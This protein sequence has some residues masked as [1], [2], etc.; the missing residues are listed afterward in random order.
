MRSQRGLAAV[1]ALLIVAVA[2]STAALMLSQQSAMLDQTSMVVAR[3][4]ADLYAQAGIDWAR[5]ILLE[6]SR[7]GQLDTLDEPWAQPIAALP[8][9]RAVVSGRIEDEQGKFNLNNLARVQG[10][11]DDQW[12]LFNNILQRAGLSLDL[13]DAVKDWVD[14]D[15]DLSALDGNGGA[16]DAYYLALARPYRTANAPMTQVDELYRVR[17]FD[18]DKVAKLRPYVTALPP[19]PAAPTPIN[20][21]TASDLVLAAITGATDATRIAALV[22]RRAKKPF[23]SPDDF[24]SAVATTVGGGA[25]NV[26]DVSSTYFAVRVQV[27]QDD[28]QLASDALL[29]RQ[30]GKSPVIIWRRPRY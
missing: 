24:R 16:E 29:Q 13:A 28:V 11:S 10:K 18:P 4:Q 17:G 19:D 14:S 23:A 15:G 20:V 21:N 8:V 1:T 9:E 30:A 6:D 25:L 3:A 27:A 7:H 5:G 22:A 12:V 26:I 2:A